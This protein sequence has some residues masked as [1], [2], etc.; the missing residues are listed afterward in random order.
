MARALALNPEKPRRS[1]VFCLWT[2]EEEGLLGSRWYVE[3]PLFSMENTLA[4]LN[5]DMIAISWDEKSLKRM[6]RMLDIDGD[7][8]L[9]KIKPENFL[10][11]SI[12]EQSPEL[13]EA[14]LAANRSVG[15]DILYRETPQRL[16]RMSG[17][18]DHSSFAMAGK[19]WAFFMS[20]M[21]DN[22]HT[23]ADSMEKFSGATMAKVSRL[24]YLAAYLLAD[25]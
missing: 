24:V 13:R 9:K 4:C 1:V 21:G 5:L 16:D 7:E 19:P 14:L 2:G 20:G 6:T 8:L 10:P 11:L 23:P 12:S 15:F 25:K 3:H 22:Y 18:S 17:G